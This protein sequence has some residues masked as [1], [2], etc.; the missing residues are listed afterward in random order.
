MASFPDFQAHKSQQIQ[1]KNIFEVKIFIIWTFSLVFGHWIDHCNLLK[2]FYLCFHSL[3]NLC[4]PKIW[5]SYQC[6]YSYKNKITTFLG[7]CVNKR[8]YYWNSYTRKNPENHFSRHNCKFFLDI[9]SIYTYSI[10]RKEDRA[11]IILDKREEVNHRQDHGHRHEH[12]HHQ[13]RIQLLAHD[14]SNWPGRK[15]NT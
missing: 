4:S 2:L 12:H 6:F 15:R 8:N 14:S 13:P 3:N 1:N 10:V 5:N 9:C 7:W 11:W